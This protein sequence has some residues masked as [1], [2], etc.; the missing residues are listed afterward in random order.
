MIARMP[1]VE[2]YNAAMGRL[3]NAE[4]GIRCPH[5]GCEHLPKQKHEVEKTIQTGPAESIKRHRI[6]RNPDC[7]KRFTTYERVAPLPTGRKIDE[8]EKSSD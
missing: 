2:E 5:C 3:L 8:G 1:T 7:G 4:R 6:C